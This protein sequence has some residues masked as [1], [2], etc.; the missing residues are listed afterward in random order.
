[1]RK[2]LLILLLFFTISCKHRFYRAASGSMEET[3]KPGDNFAVTITDKFE[4]NDIVVFD[5]YGPDYSSMD[6]ETGE[7]K[8]HWE[9]RIFR[10]IAYSGDSVKIVEGELFVNNRHIPMPPKGKLRYEVYAKTA[11][12]DF[13]TQDYSPANVKGDTLVYTVDLTS[14]KVEDLRRRKPAII[15]VKRILPE[16]YANDTAYARASEK[17]EW[18]ADNYG[19]FKIPSPGE[20]VIVDDNNYKFYHNIPG[21]QKGLNTIN[22]KFYFLMGDNRYGAEDSRYIGLIAQSKMYG[23]VE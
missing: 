10:L 20:K 16:L 22:E 13:N 4:R 17:G 2:I 19:P 23:I 12:E 1:M 7:M 14:E 15:G 8:L 3:I 21:I 9:R 6:P 18:T 5:Y 11:I